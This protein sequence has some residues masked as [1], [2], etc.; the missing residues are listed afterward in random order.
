MLFYF[1]MVS[2]P[3][4][5]VFAIFQHHAR[6]GGTHPKSV[7][8]TTAGV[9]VCVCLVCARCGAM[10]IIEAIYRVAPEPSSTRG[11]LDACV[12]YLPCRGGHLVI[13]VI[14]IDIV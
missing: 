2:E 4:N 10:Y 3:H 5:F 12:L 6:M 11:D 9:C 8:D 14:Y 1:I 7:S 13:L